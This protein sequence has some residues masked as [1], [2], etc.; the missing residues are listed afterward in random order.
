MLLNYL[1][2]NQSLN[3]DDDD[4]SVSLIAVVGIDYSLLDQVFNSGKIE[5]QCLVCPHIVIIDN[6]VRLLV[7]EAKTLEE[8]QNQAS[9]IVVSK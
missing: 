7:P 3:I 1:R 8:P 5:R 6:F 2:I 4:G 9:F